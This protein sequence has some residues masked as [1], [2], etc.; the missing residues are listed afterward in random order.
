MS[1]LKAWYTA[2]KLLGS[3]YENQRTD[4]LGTAV[5]STKAVKIKMLNEHDGGQ[6]SVENGRASLF[7]LRMAGQ[8]SPYNPPPCTLWASPYALRATDG[9][10]VFPTLVPK[11]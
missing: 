11:N 5:Y 4:P 8:A 2:G 3:F 10:S 6:G 9:R 1:K 7:E